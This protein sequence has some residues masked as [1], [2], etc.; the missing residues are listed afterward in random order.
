[1]SL[2][3]VSYKFSKNFRVVALTLNVLALMYHLIDGYISYK[4]DAVW[5]VIFGVLAINIIY[6]L[7]N[8]T[9]PPIGK[10]NV[11]SPTTTPDH[12]NPMN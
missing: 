12:I 1:M 10:P 6:I 9:I 4:F 11:P 3:E 2:Q 5:F 8:K 7:T